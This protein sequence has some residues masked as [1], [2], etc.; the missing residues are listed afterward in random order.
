MYKRVS[1][2]VLPL[3]PFLPFTQH[4]EDEEGL[5]RLHD[6]RLT[7]KPR[8]PGQSLPMVSVETY[9][10]RDVEELEEVVWSWERFVREDAKEWF[11]YEDDDD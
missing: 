1:V 3:V 8:E 11:E 7:P 10:Y 2:L 6:P 9:V 5:I 4:P